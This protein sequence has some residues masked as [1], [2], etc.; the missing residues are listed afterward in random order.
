MSC[1]VSYITVANIQVQERPTVDSKIHMNINKLHYI[2]NT[3]P[4]IWMQIMPEILS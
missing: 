4:H 1:N 3:N 2:K